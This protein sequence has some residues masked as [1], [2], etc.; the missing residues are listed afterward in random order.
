MN[1]RESPLGSTNLLDRNL[2]VGLL[3][4]C[5][6]PMPQAQDQDA[7]PGLHGRGALQAQ[8]EGVTD[9][10]EEW[11]EAEERAASGRQ[12]SVGATRLIDAR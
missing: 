7:L 4:P 10:W 8:G 6:D 11:R 5:G 9:Q 12:T 2:T 3:V 1:L